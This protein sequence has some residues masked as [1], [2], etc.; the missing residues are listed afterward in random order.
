LVVVALIAAVVVLDQAAKWWAWRYGPHTVINPGG[1]ILVGS[2]IGTWYAAPATGAVLDLLDVVL[3]SVAVSALA[4]SRASAAVLVPGAMMTGGW[5]SNLLDRLGFHYWTAPG[6]IRGVVDFIH[7]GG[8]YYNLADMFI[9]SCTPI[10]LLTAGYHAA[11]TARLPVL[12]GTNPR[13]HAAGRRLRI[14]TLAGT[15]LI[16]AVALGAANDAGVNA[17]VRTPARTATHMRPDPR[18]YPVHSSLPAYGPPQQAQPATTA[19]ASQPPN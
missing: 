4:R 7:L 13:P 8:H 14:L 17:A 15:S 2:K 9:I 5:V 16:V 6:S 10:F 19:T 12:P 1:D 11:R 18:P 3:L